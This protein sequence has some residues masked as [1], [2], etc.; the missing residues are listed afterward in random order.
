[1]ANKG[2]KSA[3]CTAFFS[4]PCSADTSI[5]F[6]DGVSDGALVCASDGA[7]DRSLP[8]VIRI[9]FFIEMGVTRN[10]PTNT[11]RKSTTAIPVVMKKSKHNSIAILIQNNIQKIFLLFSLEIIFDNGKSTNTDICIDTNASI[12][13]AIA[14]PI[15]WSPIPCISSPNCSR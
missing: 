15:P 10:A 13:K 1:M 12:N 4:K 8:F 5:V 3:A 6:S 7:P 2:S 9:P 14:I 11:A